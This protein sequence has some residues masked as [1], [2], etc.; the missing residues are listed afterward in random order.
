M[1]WLGRQI[2]STIGKEFL[3]IDFELD[4]ILYPANYGDIR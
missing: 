3:L 4:L 2:N 1:A